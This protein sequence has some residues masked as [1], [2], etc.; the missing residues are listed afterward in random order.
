M[1][2]QGEKPKDKMLQIQIQTPRGLWSMTE[3]VNAPLQPGYEPQTKVEQVIAD[4]RSVFKF[5]END[6]KYSLFFKREELAPQ[7]PLVSYGIHD[8]DLLTAL[9]ARIF[10]SITSEMSI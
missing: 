2:T 4:A 10:A 6:S 5:V 9:I 7:R 1:A 8:G 3:P